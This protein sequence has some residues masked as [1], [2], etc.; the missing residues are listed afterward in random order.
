ML[1]AY[2][3]VVHL[4]IEAGPLV[5][6]HGEVLLGLGGTGSRFLSSTSQQHGLSLIQEPVVLVASLGQLGLKLLDAER[7]R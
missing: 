2:P 3:A 7:S 4:G 6:Q 1:Q 5:L